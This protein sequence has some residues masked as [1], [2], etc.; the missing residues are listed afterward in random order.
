MGGTHW[1]RCAYVRMLLNILEQEFTSAFTEEFV[2][3]LCMDS[4]I[5]HNGF[6]KYLKL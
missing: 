3:I 5:Y 1:G 4:V 2:H 6:C